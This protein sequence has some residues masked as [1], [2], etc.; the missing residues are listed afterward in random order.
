MSQ[1]P[2]ITFGIIVLNGEPFTKYCLRSLYPFAHEI[3]VVEGATI[4]AAA[5]ATPDG[6]STDGTLETLHRFKTEE[7]PKDKMQIIIR[8]GFWS[9]KDEQS[10]AYAKRATGDYLWQVD[11]DE[12]YHPEDMQ[13][14][15]EMLANDPTISGISFFWKNFWGGFDYLVD[16]WEYRDLVKK[17]GGIRRIFKWGKGYRYVSHRPPTVVNDQDQDLR[18]LNWIGPKEMAKMGIFC[19]HYGMV[20]PKQAKQKTVYYQTTG[21]HDDMDTW[22]RESFIELRY[23]FRILHGTRPP[24]WLHRFNG[25]HPPEIKRLIEDC[26]H[27]VVNVEQRCTNDIEQLLDSPFYRVAGN[28]LSL[29]YPAKGLSYYMLSLLKRSTNKIPPELAKKPL[30]KFSKAWQRLRMPPLESLPNIPDLFHVYRYLHQHPDLERRPG[31]WVYKGKFYPDYLTVGGASHAVFRVALKYC[32]GEGI[33]VGAGLWPLPGAVPVDMWR[34]PG[35]GKTVADFSNGSLD[36]VFSSHCLEHI[37]NW[38]STLA[39]WIRKLK[40]GGIVFLYLP[41]PECEIWHPGSPFVGNGHKWV[42]TPEVVSEALRA[43]GCEIVERN[44]GPDAMMSFYIC[45]RKHEETSCSAD[46]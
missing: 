36:Y 41:H 29:L 19:Y 32:Q 12:F 10:R 24:S 5:V 1:L 40:P 23:P 30:R 38:Q 33:D 45:A 2:R 31:G 43:L 20:F 25:E 28:L 4:N 22:Y 44:D 26:A 27:G 42:P 9:E 11:I 8:D 6:H 7:D 16:G 13:L 34:G 18:T 39:E 3:I 21:F 46:S 37:E 15:I 35:V 17:I 14:I